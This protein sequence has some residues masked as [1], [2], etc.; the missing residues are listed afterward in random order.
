MTKEAA[1]CRYWN[2]RQCSRRPRHCSASCS[3]G[4][5]RRAGAGNTHSLGHCTPDTPQQHWQSDDP[6]PGPYNDS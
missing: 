5:G 6:G 1:F 3:P 4:A 2:R